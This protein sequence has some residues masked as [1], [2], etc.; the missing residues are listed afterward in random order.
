[1]SQFAS[2]IIIRGFDTPA[3]IVTE[4]GLKFENFNDAG[5]V[6]KLLQPVL[7]I[8]F[9]VQFNFLY[10]GQKNEAGIDVAAAFGFLIIG[11]FVLLLGAGSTGEAGAGLGFGLD[12]IF[13]GEG[14]D[15]LIANLQN[16]FQISCYTAIQQ[17]SFSKP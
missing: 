4:K 9:S 3:K 5:V 1:M 6:T 14:F 16:F 12:A 11:G 10:N 2:D 17:D 8:F 13:A 7:P 15:V